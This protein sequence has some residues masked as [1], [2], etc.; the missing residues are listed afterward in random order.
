MNPARQHKH[1]LSKEI[2]GSLMRRHS[3][4]A[5]LFHHAV[6]ECL[7]L[8][9]TDHKCLDLL[10][11]RGVLSGSDLA[12]ITGLTTGAITGVVARLEQAGYLRREQHPHD[13]RK[14]TLRPVV[15]R[16]RDLHG[17]FGPIRRDMAALLDAF[18]AHQLTGIAEFLAR[19]TDLIHRHAA[20]LR[21]QTVCTMNPAQTAQTPSIDTAS[22]DSEVKKTRRPVLRKRLHDETRLLSPM[23]SKDRKRSARR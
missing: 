6:A 1:S 20:L 14:Q 22:K 4:A 5:V 10:R 13:G 11:E 23:R 21:V 7:G 2:V 19:S 17:V 12:A 18:D 8:G 16:A 3:T 15:E 9:A